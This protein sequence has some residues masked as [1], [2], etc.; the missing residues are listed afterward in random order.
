MAS[1]SP[2]ACSSLSPRNT[3][4]AAFMGLAASP[5]TST[6]RSGGVASVAETSRK[7]YTIV[8]D[9]APWDPGKECLDIPKHL[10]LTAARRET[11]KAIFMPQG[12]ALVLTPVCLRQ[13]P[14]FDVSQIQLADGCGDNFNV[15][16]RA[17][18]AAFA[19]GQSLR[20]HQHESGLF[21][22][23]GGT[24]SPRLRSYA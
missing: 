3:Q 23:P 9:I 17:D 22:A 20:S 14:N 4:P 16:A 10:V 8:K 15:K 19:S 6:R 11:L 12:A 5:L 21:G 2:T 18:E 7:H 13:D 24:Y 1:L